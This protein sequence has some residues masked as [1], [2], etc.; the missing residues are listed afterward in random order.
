MSFLSSFNVSPREGHLEAAYWVSKYLYFHKKGGRVV[1][2]DVE[3]EVKE[4]QFKKVN[5][6]S[7]YGDVVED[8]LCNM[9]EPRENPEVILMFIDAAF[10]GDLV[11]RRSQSS[12][13]IFLNRAP[14]TWYS[15]RQN[16][17]EASTFGSKFIALRVGCEMNDGLR[18][19]LRMMGVPIKGP[20]NVCCDNEAVVNNSS[21]AEYS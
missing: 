8:I 17:V 13:L 9:P 10:T 16:T 18:Y 14:I 3:P 15:K 19:K 2:N 12:I 6:K 7:L 5:W 20:T 21:L 11:T 1:F 4:E